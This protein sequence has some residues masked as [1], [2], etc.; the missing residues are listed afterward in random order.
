MVAGTLLNYTTVDQLLRSAQKDDAEIEQMNAQLNA[1]TCY[2][3]GSGGMLAALEL[4]ESGASPIV[5]CF[6]DPMCAPYGNK[7]DHF[8]MSRIVSFENFIRQ[9]LPGK[10]YG[11][12]A[13]NTA[14]QFLNHLKEHNH[15]DEKRGPRR[16]II[17]PI[18][19][20]VL[21]YGFHHQAWST[22]LLE[23]G[24]KPEELYIG[25][26]ATESTIQ[27]GYYQNV[28]RKALPDA[29][30][31]GIACPQLAT[32]ID[33]ASTVPELK[34]YVE[35]IVAGYISPKGSEDHIPPNAKM[36][37]VLGCTHFNRVVEHFREWFNMNGIEPLI[38]DQH[39]LNSGYVRQEIN[40]MGLNVI[41]H[42]SA[43]RM[44]VYT[45]GETQHAKT[46]MQDLLSAREAERQ[47]EKE[48]RRKY[49]EPE[50]I[51]TINPVKLHEIE[52]RY[53]N[54]PY[55]GL[56]N[57]PTHENRNNKNIAGARVY[58]VP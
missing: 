18:L 22:D 25:I 36:I 54:I 3:T 26:F 33:S 5:H 52:F 15:I 1:V 6:I 9:E 29:I 40:K 14:S 28:L 32:M 23:E 55:V 34:A 56:N 42:A 16:S 19:Q 58:T 44:I 2:D 53:T 39:R 20:E 17:D 45:T 8:I 4:I 27:R 13:C 24:K 7:S 11:I 49:G 38:L 47:K 57:I 35:R 51:Q 37:V 31:T 10:S 21:N 48:E 12:I 43:P 46:M 30:V 41:W 50:R